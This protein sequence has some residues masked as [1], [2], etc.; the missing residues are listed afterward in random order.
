MSDAL[1]PEALKRLRVAVDHPRCGGAVTDVR[2]HDLRAL[3]AA[4]VAARVINDEA[5]AAALG[6]TGSD[7]TGA[8]SPTSRAGVVERAF[9]R[10][11]EE[12]REACAQWVMRDDVTWDSMSECGDAIRGTPI[13][14][15]PLADERDELMATV[16]TQRRVSEELL[17]EW[18]AKEALLTR[19]RDEARARVTELEAQVATARA[20]IEDDTCRHDDEKRAVLRA[21]DEAHVTWRCFICDEVFTTESD[22]RDHF[23]DGY[24]RPGCVDPLAKDEKLRLKELR[25]AREVARRW[26]KEKEVAESSARAQ[27]DHVAQYRAEVV[28]LEKQRDVAEQ[29]QHAVAEELNAIE[30]VS[31]CRVPLGLEETLAIIKKLKEKP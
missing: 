14:T 29:W 31:D 8:H 9:A 16:K 10:V 22:A 2:T 18:R 24:E 13:T 12:Q 4:Y 7:L 15:T 26:L 30:P 17:D 23:T 27:S 20:F 6:A 25:Y 3:L 1:T 21:M 5:W 11:R 19:E 28:R